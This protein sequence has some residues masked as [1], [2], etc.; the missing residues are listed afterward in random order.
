MAFTLSD[1]AGKDRDWGLCAT[2][3]MYQLY[4]S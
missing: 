2:S 1:L 4:L 3:T